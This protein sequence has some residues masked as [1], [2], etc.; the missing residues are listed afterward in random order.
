[1]S[2][3]LLPGLAALALLVPGP[4]WAQWSA[5]LA[6]E[7]PLIAGNST[8]GTTHSGFYTVGDSFQ[9]T[10]DVIGSYYFAQALSVDLEFRRGLTATGTG[11]SRPL[12]YLGP[13]LTLDAP[14]FPLYGRVAV[15][16]QIE[17]AAAVFFRLGGGWKVIEVA[18][19]RLYIELT[20][21]VPL[22]GSGVKFF[23]GFTFNAGVGL[24]LR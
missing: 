18:F 5:R 9:P 20:T 7:A 22:G 10:L 15:P 8:T 4:A 19:I 11:Y 1:M 16:I 13:G 2:S 24:W 17:Q 3:A 6:L 21:D 23:S 14:A 12:T